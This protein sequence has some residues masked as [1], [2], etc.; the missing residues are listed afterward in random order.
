[1]VSRARDGS[2]RMTMR[3]YSEL[4]LL[5]QVYLPGEAEMTG[6]LEEC[7][8]C[9]GTLDRLRAELG[10]IRDEFDRRI[11]R[12][13]EAFWESQR[14]A[15]LARA[16]GRSARAFTFSPFRTWAL[17]ASLVIAVGGGWIVYDRLQ[18]PPVGSPGIVTT[19]TTGTSAAADAAEVQLP[20][21]DPWAS[22]ELAGWETAVD[23][24][25]WL[26]PGDLE[27]GGA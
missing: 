3:H 2:G 23:W 7:A 14:Q 26:E 4:E 5:D 22:E 1:M 10:S 8:S 12:K 16:R 6:H 27:Q 24:E 21:A 19:A 13:P 17:A 15:I 18:E 9:R 11:D 25:S 20:T